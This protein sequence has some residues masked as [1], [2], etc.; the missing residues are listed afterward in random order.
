MMSCR[1]KAMAKNIIIST[2][3]VTKTKTVNASADAN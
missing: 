1:A 2:I 3:I